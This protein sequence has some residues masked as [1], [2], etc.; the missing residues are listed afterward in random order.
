MPETTRNVRIAA[1][2]PDLELAGTWTLP[3]NPSAV[4]LL[5]PGAGPLDRDASGLGQR[6]FLHLAGQLA[7]HGIATLRCDDRGVGESGGD[8][9]AADEDVILADARQQLQWIKQEFPDLALGIIGHAQGA[10]FAMRL[11]ATS[12]D[13]HRL[14]L[15]SANFRPGMTFMMEM[16]EQLAGDTGLS[17]EELAAYM[18]HSRE[19]FWAITEIDDAREREHK[20]RE[21]IRATVSHAEDI[22]FQPDFQ[23]V[24]QYVE[25]AARDSLE[26]EIRTLLRS[27]PA[28]HLARLTCPVLALWGERDRHLDP[29]VEATTFQETC[30]PPNKGEI[31]PGMNHIFQLSDTGRIEDYPHDGPPMQPPLPERIAAWFSQA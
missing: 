25:F 8:Y 11:A 19:L 9:L 13:V 31:L 12:P 28:E 16:R 3:E 17:G 21:V 20:V 24:D 5:L 15:L 4:A 14:V 23:S 6:P 2:S 22:D 29:E 30:E 7:Q 26:W 27:R 1:S 10:L 18:E